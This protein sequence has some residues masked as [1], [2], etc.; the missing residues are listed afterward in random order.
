MMNIFIRMLGV[1]TL[2]FIVFILFCLLIMLTIGIL[3]WFLSILKL[4]K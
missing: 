2:A 4:E 1:I 3:S